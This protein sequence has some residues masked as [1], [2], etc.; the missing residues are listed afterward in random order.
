MKI[1]MIGGGYVGL[2]SSAC[3]AAFGATVTLVEKDPQRLDALQRGEIPIYEPGLDALL[4]EQRAVGRL[5]LCSSIAQGLKEAE[6]VFIAVGTPARRGSG[7]ADLSYVYAV[8]R[9]IAEAAPHNL[10]IV[11]KSTVPVGTGREVSRI[12]NSLR[13]DLHFSVASNPEFLREGQ[14]IADFMNPDRVIIGLDQKSDDKG[15]R[16][17]E[18]LTTLYHPLN[19]PETRLVFMGLE[20]A[21]LTKYAANAFLAMKVT[22]AN[23]MADLCEATGADSDEVRHAIGLDPRIGPDFLIPGPGFGGSCFPKDTQALAVTARKAGAPSPLVETTIASNE[24]RKRRMAERILTLLGDLT[25]PRTV[26]ILGLTFKANTDDMRQAPSLTVL[27]LLYE[28]GLTLRVYDPHGMEQARA[29]LP[30]GIYFA[31]NALDAAQGTD[32][33]VILTEWE[34]FL[35]ITPSELQKSMKGRLIVDYRGLWKNRE[36]A[37]CG[38]VYH[39]IGKKDQTKKEGT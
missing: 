13:P 16:A 15:T 5:V 18:L 24:A 7:H 25:H 14:A 35:H 8:A 9:E 20:S 38:L 21:E 31:R 4:C 27:P 29:L 12:V 30:D 22:F 33:L 36:F 26:A 32:L 39:R 28:A 11:T 34:E 3:L 23:E 19:H 10:L 1:T 6:A 17:R 37:S 2:V